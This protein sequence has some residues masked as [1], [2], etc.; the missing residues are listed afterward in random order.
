M[1][2]G[3]TRTAVDGGLVVIA[4]L[5]VW[6]G[7]HQV[8]GA[9]A[10]PAPVP[11]FSYLGHLVVTPRFLEN[12]AA[13][14]RTFAV[15]LG[16]AWGLGLAIGI[17]MGM[18]RLAGEVGEPILIALYSMPKITLYPVV[19]L[20]FG[21]GT[22]AEVAFGVMHGALPVAILTMNAIRKVRPVFLK[23]ARTM[24]LKPRQTILAVVL[25]A[26]LPEVVTGLRYGFTLTVLGVLLGEM[27]AAKHGLG[28]MLMNAINLA[29][30]EEMMTIAVVIFAFAAAANGILLWV[31]HR[32]HR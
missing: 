26:S 14:L 1:T 20:I 12:A 5:L 9:T 15:A 7:L 28:V 17:W 11:T 10:L 19:L 6:Q 18:R 13:S 31:E 3:L 16:I 4:L 29:R 25:P 27:F 2:A 21:L 30:A 22:S 23:M 8:V 32:L 24:N